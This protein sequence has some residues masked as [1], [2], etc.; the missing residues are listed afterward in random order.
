MN[1]YKN[2]HRYY[3]GIDLHAR[4]MYVCILNNKGKVLVH[5]NIKTDPELFFE[6]IFPYIEDI[7]SALNASFVGTGL[8]TFVPSTK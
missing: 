2:Q 5:Q 3:C 6:I 7:L 1:F 4:K 8:Q